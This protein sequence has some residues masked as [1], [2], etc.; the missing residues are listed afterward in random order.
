MYGR[1][2]TG[3]IAATLLAVP[4]AAQAVVVN[5]T[6]WTSVAGNQLSASGT[7][8]GVTVSVSS[9]VAMNG[10]S[11][12]AGGTNYW[13]EPDPLDRPYTG[14]TVS[15]APTASEQIGLNS[16]TT[17]TVTFSSPVTTLY[18]A[19]LSVGQ[20]GLAVTYDFINQPCVIDSEGKGYWGNDATDGVLAGNTLA[21]REFHGLLRFTSPVSSLTFSTDPAEN[22]HA[23]T[24][25]TPVPLPAAG[26]LL[27]SA[28]GGLG[29]LGRRRKAS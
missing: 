2:A 29:I 19:L 14:G 18:M 21:M 6:D 27:L 12:T 28:L 23:F 13:T 11:Q 5:W 20:P 10:P 24:F 25:G 16:A 26:W 17:V 9:I 22:W 4:M 7:M 1:F 8:G 15:N 3:L